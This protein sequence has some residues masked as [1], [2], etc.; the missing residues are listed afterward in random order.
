MPASRNEAAARTLLSLCG[1]DAVWNAPAAADVSVGAFGRALKN[2]WVTCRSLSRVTTTAA[3][4][5]VYAKERVGAW[6]SKA[7]VEHPMTRFSDRVLSGNTELLEVLK[8]RLPGDFAAPRCNEGPELVGVSLRFG[9]TPVDLEV[10]V[11]RPAIRVPVL[12][13]S[14][15][16]SLVYG[17]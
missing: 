4:P 14:T 12:W 6:L 7:L 8:L 17:V 10:G 11:K 16:Q 15:R 1:V 9:I 2:R 5:A 3:A 13:A